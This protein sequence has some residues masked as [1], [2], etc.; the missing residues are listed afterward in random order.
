MWLINAQTIS[1]PAHAYE[2]LLKLQNYNLLVYLEMGPQG[3]SPYLAI[4]ILDDLKDTF[5][6]TAKSEEISKFINLIREDNMWYL[7]ME[8]A[9]VKT[10]FSESFYHETE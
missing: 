9:V 2:F 10:I 6:Q 4:R 7:S 5:F 1:M 3:D 8:E